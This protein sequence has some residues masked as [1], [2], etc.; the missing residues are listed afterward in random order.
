MFAPVTRDRPSWGAAAH[1]NR[2]DLFGIVYFGLVFIFHFPLSSFL[3]GQGGRGGVSFGHLAI[4]S[5]WQCGIHETGISVLAPHC[6]LLPVVSS[7]FQW[8]ITRHITRHAVLDRDRD[9]AWKLTR[10]DRRFASSAGTS[11]VFT[12][13]L[14][15]REHGR[16]YT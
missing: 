10:V 15:E 3:I 13:N 6:S 14:P 11:S 9:D 1:P 16:G 4:V 2:P 5:S 7:P 12:G 8:H